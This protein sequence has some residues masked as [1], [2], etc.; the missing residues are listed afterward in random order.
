MM[1]IKLAAHHVECNSWGCCKHSAVY[2]CRDLLCGGIPDCDYRQPCNADSD[3]VPYFRLC[4]GTIFKHLRFPGFFA[5][6]EP[7]PHLDL[8]PKRQVTQVGIKVKSLLYLLN[9]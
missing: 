6:D 8:Q 2:G 5:D 9:R 3:R 4:T 1:H 7:D